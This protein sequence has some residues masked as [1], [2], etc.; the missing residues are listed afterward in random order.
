MVMKHFAAC[1]APIRGVASCL[2][3]GAGP[4]ESSFC[5]SPFKYLIQ[6]SANIQDYFVYIYMLYV[7]T[8]LDQIYTSMHVGTSQVLQVF[9]ILG[10]WLAWTERELVVRSCICFRGSEG[11]VLC[12]A[13]HDP[14]WSNGHGWT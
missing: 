6:N 5:L 12:L 2:R 4:F 8:V 9:C 11:T 13:S 3:T 10:L 1:P 7:G 14:P